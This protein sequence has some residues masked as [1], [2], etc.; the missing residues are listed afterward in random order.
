[1][2]PQL[3]LDREPKLG[4]SDSHEHSYPDSTLTNRTPPQFEVSSPSS[5]SGDFN[6]PKLDL[7]LQAS[8]SFRY[9]SSQVYNFKG[10][11]L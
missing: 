5:A 1:M 6:A 3:G 2:K 10:R 4:N 8:L 7:G 11:L 9:T